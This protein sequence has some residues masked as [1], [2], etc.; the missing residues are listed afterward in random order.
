[1]MFLVQYWPGG[2]L[3]QLEIYL[4]PFPT[5]VHFIYN[6]NYASITFICSNLKIF[7]GPETNISVGRQNC[8]TGL[9]RMRIT[10]KKSTILKTLKTSK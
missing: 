9:M 4:N 2:K 3:Y 1:M 8:D 5:V 6:C 10:S 7:A